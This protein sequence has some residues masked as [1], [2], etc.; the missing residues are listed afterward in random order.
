MASTQA[1][2]ERVIRAESPTHFFVLLV[3]ENGFLVGLNELGESALF[4]EADDGVI[5]DRHTDGIKHVVSG[6]AVKASE[7]AQ[8]LTM[9]IDG[10]DMAVSVSRGPEKLPSEYL[11]ELR[12]DGLVCL[13]SIVGSDVVEGL[14][15]VACVGPYEALEPTMGIPKI[16]QDAAV[17]RALTEPVSLWV[18]RQYLGHHDIHLGHPP[19]MAVVHPDQL[20]RAGRGW[21]M[22]QP[23]TR[24]NSGQVFERSGPP[25]SCNRNIC[26]SDF[27]HLNGATAF[28][29]GSH[30]GDF[31]VP[32]DWNA[33]LKEDPPRMSYSGPDATVYEA[34]SGSIILY[35]AR[36]WHRAGYNRSEHKRAAMLSSGQVPEVIPKTDANHAYNRLK[37][38]PVFGQL[39]ERQQLEVGSLMLST[40]SSS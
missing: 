13:D 26:V 22:D 36:T 1:F 37:E 7:D 23:Y 30:S 6:R 33:P 14:R 38:T 32:E 40:P 20:A 19:G 27:T 9:S 21:H 34:P 16:C 11:A 25:K 5:W 39:N 10:Q 31:H 4:T 17:G 8:S 12:R 24:S 29:S 3:A 28:V 2:T 15:R 18:L 35:D